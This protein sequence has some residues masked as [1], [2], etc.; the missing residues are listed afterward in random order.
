ML[1]VHDISNVS[2]GVIMG[3][4]VKGDFFAYKGEVQKSYELAHIYLCQF[5]A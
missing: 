3:Y 5:N 2:K 1:L 4:R